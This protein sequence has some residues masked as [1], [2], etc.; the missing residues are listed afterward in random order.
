[1]KFAVSGLVLASI[2]LSGCA[3]SVQKSSTHA[4]VI[5][6]PAASTK[7]IVLNVTGKP[8][9]LESADW[10]Q[11]KGEWRAAMKA[12]AASIGAKFSS[13]DSKPQPTGEVGTLVVV[14]INDYRYVSPGARYGLGVLTGNAYMDAKVQFND[15]E[16]GSSFGERAY[17]SSSTAW[18]GVFSAMT[19]KQVQAM[20]LEIVNEIKAG[21]KLAQVAP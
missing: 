5:G 11:F 15:L 3:A 2:L 9:L 7:Q 21:P 18:Q 6:I 14:N 13:Q 4:T 20:C 19:E 16:T 8:E 1:M 10:E 17:N 12:A